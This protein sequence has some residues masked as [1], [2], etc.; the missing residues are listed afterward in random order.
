LL[1]DLDDETKD[2][3][4]SLIQN[5]LSRLLMRIEEE[6]QSISEKSLVNSNLT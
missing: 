2:K 4:Q 1:K 5:H 6:N 3:L